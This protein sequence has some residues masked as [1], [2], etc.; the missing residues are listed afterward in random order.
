[1]QRCE[2]AE[3]AWEAANLAAKS[4]DMDAGNL[5]KVTEAS[6]AEEKKRSAAMA[7]LQ[8]KAAERLAERKQKTLISY[9][10]AA[11]AAA[12]P[13]HDGVDAVVHP[14]APAAG[15]PAGGGAEADEVVDA[16]PA[17]EGGQWTL[18]LWKFECP[19]FTFGSLVPK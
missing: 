10:V 6:K 12:V 13:L 15:E 3:K 17:N 1:M 16:E 7:G 8:E 5:N 18:M 11:E 9:K 19:N 2:I 4:G 14:A